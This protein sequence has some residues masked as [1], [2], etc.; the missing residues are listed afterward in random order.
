MQVSKFL[1]SNTKF[2][3]KNHRAT[4]KFGE[5]TFAKWSNTNFYR[6]SYG[7]MDTKVGAWSIIGA[8]NAPKNC[9]AGRYNHNPDNLLTN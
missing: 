4:E 3:F 8:T 5:D 9:Q 1:D 6:T 7:D 2:S